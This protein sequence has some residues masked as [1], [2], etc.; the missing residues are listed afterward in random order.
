MEGLIVATSNDGL[1]SAAIGEIC[2]AAC[3]ADVAASAT[4]ARAI[5]SVTAALDG[6]PRTIV[7]EVALDE[8]RLNRDGQDHAA[9]PP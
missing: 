9:S 1:A 6:R 4:A 5:L 7:A 3:E 2:G 8:G